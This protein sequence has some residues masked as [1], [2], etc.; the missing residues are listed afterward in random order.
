[1]VRRKRRSIRCLI[2]IFIVLF[3][4][5]SLDVMTA[6]DKPD[7]FIENNDNISVSVSWSPNNTY[8]ASGGYGRIMIWDSNSGNNIKNLS[9]C[10]IG[11]YS[12]DW[13]PDSNKIAAITLEKGGGGYA[14]YGR[15]VVVN[16]TTGNWIYN[17]TEHGTL[18]DSV[19][20]SPDG[21]LIASGSSNDST[22][23]IWNPETGNISRTINSSDEPLMVKWSPDGKY[24]LGGLSIW[25]ISSGEKI[26]E[27]DCG[28]YEFPHSVDW[29][30]DGSKIV[31]SADLETKVWDVASGTC[32]YTF[33][34]YGFVSRNRMECSPNSNL[35]AIG[36][37][38]SPPSNNG[39]IEIRNLITG[40]LVR[41]ITLSE[42]EESKSVSWSPDG[43][44][45][46]VSTKL[47]VKVFHI[48]SYINDTDDD[49]VLDINDDFPFD[50]AA[51]LD[52]DGDGFPDEWNPGM[53]PNNST[54]NLTK[55]D[56]FPYNATQ[57]NDTDNDGWGDNYANATWLNEREWPVGAQHIPNAYRPDRFPLKATQWNDTD[58]DGWGDNYANISWGQNR[59]IGIYIPNAYKP[60]RYPLDPTRWNDTDGNNEPSDFDG[61][62]IP[63]YLDLDIDG[64]GW[65]NTIEMEIGTDVWDNRSFPSDLDSDGIPDALDPDIDNDRWN[66][67]I[68]LEV[69]TDPYNNQSFPS[70]LDRDGIP[71]ILDLDIDGD[72]WN[73]TIEME[74]GTD[75]WDNTSYPT[76]LDR[77]GIP[78]LI[79]LD[80]DGDG[81]NN[82]IEIEVSTDPYDN[83]SFPSDLDHDGIPDLI[84]L[85][86]D[87]DGWKNLIELE[88]GTDPYNNKSFPSDLDNDSI[89]DTLDPDIDGDGVLNED[90][91]YPD[92]GGRAEREEEE[93]DGAVW[94]I[95]G[96]VVGVLVVGV[97]VGV[98]LVR[99]RM[100]KGEGE[101][102]CG[103]RVIKDG[104]VDEFKTAEMEGDVR[105]EEV[106]KKVS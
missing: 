88:V 26:K 45:I 101:E 80:I 13:S 73:N 72:G 16:A 10:G 9:V 70:D 33:I 6:E 97:I 50:P 58:G 23:K 3:I 67:T 104:T 32:I 38:V 20:W 78:D 90:D 95:V 43:K 93:G 100:G 29:S 14:N 60:D 41:N 5:S 21:S 92:D 48:F 57:W 85:D 82:T 53:G 55:L 51:A 105:G 7:L 65:N 19:D 47:G 98:I 54:T 15:V 86:I 74:I 94:G 59:S 79:D 76:D 96:I 66:N 37:G 61:D 68:E 103:E 56:D 40:D 2:L 83:L 62:G 4:I 31:I 69:G 84:D 91:A 17:F 49:G 87:G 71:D 30:Y 75:V 36:Q 42:G 64:D 63:D 99:R 18:I 81:W 46:A 89:P 44:S 12:L 1:M 24:L 11:I 52:S 22:I 39:T 27:F 34:H 77:D 106:D 35:F 8:I 102:V 25:N 28:E